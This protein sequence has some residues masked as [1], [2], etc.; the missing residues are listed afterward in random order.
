VPRGF[1]R[2]LDI[3]ANVAVVVVVVVLVAQ[4]TGISRL[5]ASPFRT[6]ADSGAPGAA[7]HQQNV[8]KLQRLASGAHTRGPVD[9]KVHI[10]VF[11]SYRCGHCVRFMA[12]IDEI[13]LKYPDHVAL[14]YRHNEGKPNPLSAGYRFALGAECAGDQG[15]FNEFSAAVYR[16]TASH[17]TNP[18]LDQIATEVGVPDVPEL[19]DCV[20]RRKHA[21][22]LAAADSLVTSMGIEVTPVWF[23]DEVPRLGA[24]APGE[25]ET[26]I[27][28]AFGRAEAR[29]RMISRGR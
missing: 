20:A 8:T 16:N 12:E 2:T 18:V 22:T 27:L 4:M 5:A 26:I 14:S 1:G 19:L 13:L 21:P 28:K 10:V 9:P 11:G 23:I 24:P 17:A 3:A 7:H 25:F 6:S 15:M 29:A